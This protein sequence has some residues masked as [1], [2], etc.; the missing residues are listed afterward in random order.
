[1]AE[2]G[3]GVRGSQLGWHHTPGRVKLWGLFPSC[4]DRGGRSCTERAEAK[5]PAVHRESL[6]YTELLPQ[7]LQHP[8][9]VG[10]P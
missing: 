7:R 3:R 4:I 2:S 10:R 1:M 5:L 6:T 9:R 8:G